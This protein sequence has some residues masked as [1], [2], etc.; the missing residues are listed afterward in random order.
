M[1]VMIVIIM[2]TPITQGSNRKRRLRG[3]NTSAPAKW[4]PSLMGT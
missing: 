2:M 1:I 4:L 3:S